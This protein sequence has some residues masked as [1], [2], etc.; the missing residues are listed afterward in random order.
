VLHLTLADLVLAIVLSAG[1]CATNPS[2]PPPPPT[3]LCDDANVGGPDPD[4][5]ECAEAVAAAMTELPLIHGQV[6][7]IRFDWGTYCPS[8]RHCALP[9]T[10]VGTVFFLFDDSPQEWYIELRKS[11]GT[12]R[13]ISKLTSTIE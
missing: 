3:V 6:V 13:A 5:L 9:S 11:A 12:I 2:S 4:R 8:G 7:R 10:D 1:G